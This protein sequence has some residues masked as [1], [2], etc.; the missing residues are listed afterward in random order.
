MSWILEMLSEMI[1]VLETIS[2]LI[3]VLFLTELTGKEKRKD[4]K[5]GN[6]DFSLILVTECSTTC[7]PLTG[8]NLEMISKIQE[9]WWL[10]INIKL[11]IFNIWC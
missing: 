8:S 10:D 7:C 4:K 2:S 3:M 9:L 11:L 6:S 1:I 5:K